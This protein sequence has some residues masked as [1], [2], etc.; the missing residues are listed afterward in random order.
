MKTYKNSDDFSKQ[1]LKTIGTESPSDHFVE[2]VMQSIRAT[3][4]VASE[5]MYKP[6][7]SKWGWLLI[8]GLISIIASL[9]MYGTSDFTNVFAGVNID[10][11][12]WMNSLEF[13]NYLEIPKLFS[14]SFLLFTVL[15]LF[16]FSMI[17]NYFNRLYS[18]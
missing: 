16:Q 17:K 9:L 18:V 11:F 1:I 8:V 4:L 7:I 6:L 13:W 3:K 12:S 14:F 10:V 5:I 2:D 15:A